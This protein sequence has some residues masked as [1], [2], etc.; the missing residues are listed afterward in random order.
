MIPA[1][2]PK[3]ATIALAFYH[4]I[5]RPPLS[6]PEHESQYLWFHPNDRHDLKRAVSAE[7]VQYYA[8]GRGR[9]MD[10]CTTTCP[11]GNDGR[12]VSL[13]EEMEMRRRMN[14]V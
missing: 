6:S 2:L 1:M 4:G 11:G 10:L 3:P 13:R 7:R 5:R 8:S 9:G 12:F 14:I